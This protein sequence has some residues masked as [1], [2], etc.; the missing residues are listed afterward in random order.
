MT[1]WQPCAITRT[2]RAF[3]LLCSRQERIWNDTG[4]HRHLPLLAVLHSHIQEE[5]KWTIHHKLG[6]AGGQLLVHA[7]VPQTPQATGGGVGCDSATPRNGQLAVGEATTP[8]VGL[9]SSSREQIVLYTP[10]SGH[11]QTVKWLNSSILIESKL[12]RTQKFADT[13]RKCFC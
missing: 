8:V 2:S 10:V 1:H 5:R 4:R 13:T 3:R 6:N 11:P 12:A 7:A 9:S